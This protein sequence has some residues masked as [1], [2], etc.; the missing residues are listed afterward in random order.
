MCNETLVHELNE[1]L[2]AE[3]GAAL[4]YAYQ[5]SMCYGLRAAEARAMFRRES[6]EEFEHAR[7][8]ADV[9]A[10][11]GGEPVTTPEDFAKPAD[12][13][14]MLTLD[15]EQE[16][17]ASENYA[18]H[19]RHAEELGNVELKVRLEEMAAEESGHAREL[20]RLLHRPTMESH[21][22]AAE[23]VSCVGH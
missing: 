18:N 16:E 20:R 9:I 2:A 1:D 23:A 7:F 17:R 6:M 15:L 3:W 10:D 4:R 12:V 5:A 22:A 19:A 8:L 14:S 21:E 13:D 11:L